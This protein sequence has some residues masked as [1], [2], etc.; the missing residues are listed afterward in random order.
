MPRL[1]HM[2]GEV[3]VRNLERKKC[4]KL[5]HRLSPTSHGAQP[6]NG[7]PPQDHAAQ[8]G[9]GTARQWDTRAC[10]CQPATQDPHLHGPS[11]S[12]QT[13]A[14]K[15]KLG[16][17]E[18]VGR[19]VMA[20]PGPCIEPATHTHGLHLSCLKGS[21]GPAHHS[22]CSPAMQRPLPIARKQVR[23]SLWTATPPTSSHSPQDAGIY[24]ELTRPHRSGSLGQILCSR[25]LESKSNMGTF[26]EAPATS[27]ALLF[28]PRPTKPW[29]RGPGARH[30][31]QE[32]Y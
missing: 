11:S 25:S 21:R 16:L 20:V 13:L 9:L 26:R 24:R 32:G 12:S 14:A 18:V 17:G 3:S 31:T 30:H 27:P 29:V 15:G 1:D 2:K 7:Y 28:P 22:S 19:A 5:A 8:D 6:Q 23:C 10:L 4:S